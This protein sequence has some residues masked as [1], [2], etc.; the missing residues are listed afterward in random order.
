M[1][2]ARCAYAVRHIISFL[3]GVFTFRPAFLAAV[4]FV[5]NLLVVV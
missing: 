5:H 2:F 3:E 4:W 1:T